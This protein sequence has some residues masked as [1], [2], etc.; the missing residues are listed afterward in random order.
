MTFST[1]R[2]DFVAVIFSLRNVHSP[3]AARSALKYKPDRI[4][5]ITSKNTKYRFASSGGTPTDNV[6]MV[7]SSV[8]L[9]QIYRTFGK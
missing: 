2:T 9:L 3:L 6:Y 1:I 4:T 7:I 5:L 8:K